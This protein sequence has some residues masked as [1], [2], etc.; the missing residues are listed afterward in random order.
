M[1]KKI[2]DKE[3]DKVANFIK[4]EFNFSVNKTPF[5]NI[6]IYEKNSIMGVLIYSLIYNRIEIDYIATKLEYQNKKIASELLEFLIENEK[7]IEN[8]TLEVRVS[9]QIAI[10]LYKKYNFKIIT[11][12][13]NYYGSED[14]YL[15]MRE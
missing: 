3:F 7:N 4:Q 5:V 8:I 11:L 15:M 10:H 12:R 14:A 2:T 13:K 9:N 1:I 6:L